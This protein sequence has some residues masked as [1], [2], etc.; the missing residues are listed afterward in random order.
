MA[1]DSGKRLFHTIVVAGAALGGC[2][3]K[4]DDTRVD[5]SESAQ[6]AQHADDAA[7]ADDSAGDV[8]AEAGGLVDA[9]VPEPRDSAADSPADARS[10][11][12]R[13]PHI[14]M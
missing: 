2:G 10:E 13:F 1:P 3:G 12:V 7:H 4:A 8:S 5:G 6:D 14:V 9:S 11:D